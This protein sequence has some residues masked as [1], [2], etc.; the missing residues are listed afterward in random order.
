MSEFQL[1]PHGD[2]LFVL[3]FPESE[4]WSCDGE[5][6]TV[7]ELEAIRVKI[8]EVLATER[9][10]AAGRRAIGDTLTSADPQPP[11]G[12]R[13]RDDCG[14]TWVNDGYYPV[15][16]VRPDLIAQGIHDPESWGKV[17]GNYGPVTVLEWGDDD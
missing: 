7:D 3:A 1:E 6:L 16:W 10:N 9:A 11:M 17:A 4:H 12:T 14:S 5:W 8:G 2:G 15:C 13:V